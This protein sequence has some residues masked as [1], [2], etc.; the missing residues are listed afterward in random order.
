MK[1]NHFNYQYVKVRKEQPLRKLRVKST[2]NY[3]QNC[4]LLIYKHPLSLSLKVVPIQEFFLDKIDFE[5][6]HK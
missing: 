5:K 1:Q 3:H 4:Y 2:K 6:N